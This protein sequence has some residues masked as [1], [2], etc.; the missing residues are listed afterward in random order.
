MTEAEWLACADPVPMLE[1]L[2]AHERASARKLRL[3]AVAC[4]RRLGERNHPLARAA[5]DVAELFADG[6]AT[7]EA[8]RAARLA[9][10]H[11][12]ESAAWYAAITRPEI[13]ARNAALSARAGSPDE[14]AAQAELLR[15]IIGNSFRP[16]PSR[17]PV[18]WIPLAQGIYEDGAF[19]RVRE[20]AEMP[21]ACNMGEIVA[22]CR[23]TGAHVRGCWVIDLLLGKQ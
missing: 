10:K 11:A 14:C 19:E 5:V 15:D 20:F 12:D 9:C 18:T 21:S 7:A 22:H 23:Q 8:M 6:R 1:F 13:A 3:F 4:A 2:Q 17:F 16:L